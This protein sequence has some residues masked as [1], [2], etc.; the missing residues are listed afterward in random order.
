METY[1]CK[2][3]CIIHIQPCSACQAV[4]SLRL[5]PPAHGKEV[6]DLWSHDRVDLDLREISFHPET[7][8]ELATAG[9]IMYKLA[10][11]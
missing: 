3:N 7:S 1:F 4:L 9:I 6:A 8:L 11:Y 10:V 2:N 5:R